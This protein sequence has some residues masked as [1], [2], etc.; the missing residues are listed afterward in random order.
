MHG[1]NS[2]SDKTTDSFSSLIEQ[3]IMLNKA[4]EGRRAQILK[5]DRGRAI[6]AQHIISTGECWVCLTQDFKTELDSSVWARSSGQPPNVYNGLSAVRCSDNKSF[7]MNHQHLLDD[8]SSNPWT[9]FILS[10]NIRI[11]ISI[12]ISSSLDSDRAREIL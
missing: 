2:W 11:S 1:I 4:G 6:T 9:K 8:L 3:D 10:W 5:A 7:P 12:S